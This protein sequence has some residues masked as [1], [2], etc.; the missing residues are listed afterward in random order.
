MK[1]PMEDE[2]DEWA[3]FGDA[4]VAPVASVPTSGVGGV[5]A[6]EH[7]YFKKRIFEDEALKDW[8]QHRAIGY[9]RTFCPPL[10]LEAF[11]DSQ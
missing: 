11:E 4:P 3:L 2:S 7:P 5:A 1:R 8:L 10:F 9:F 6:S